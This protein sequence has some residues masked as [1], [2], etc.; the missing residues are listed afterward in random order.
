MDISM[1]RERIT[2]SE[3]SVTQLNDYVKRIIDNDKLLSAVSV[4]GEISNLTVHRSGHLYFTLKDEG[5]QVKAVMFRSAASRL[6][7]EP[8][9][10]MKV[11]V[12]CSVSVYVQTGSYQLYVNSMQPDGIGALYLAYEQL[13]NKLAEEG[14]FDGEHKL[15]IP[16][17]PLKIGVITS[18]TGAAIRDIIN[19]L[20]RR[21]PLA[22]VYLYPSLVQGEYAEENL[23]EAVDYF[24]KSKLADVVIIGRGGGSIEDLWAFNSERLARR[25]YECQVPVIS[26]V[27]HETD[28]TIC[29]FVSDMR[30]PTPSAA[31]ELASPDKFELLL[32][33]DA[34]LDRCSNILIS[35][36]Q[37]YEERLLSLAKSPYLT[38]SNAVFSS[39]TEKISELKKKL[40]DIKNIFAENQEVSLRYLSGKLESLNPLA[41]LKRGY[42]VICLSDRLVRLVDD[43]EVG[44]RVDITLSD[45]KAIA[46]IIEKRKHDGNK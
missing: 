39:Q 46:K 29:D 43:I 24:D 8:E 3:M 30:A 32:R 11:I 31:A 13:K 7:F 4:K 14:L 6:R 16:Q 20:G 19:V 36:I 27:G 9:N 26:A 15:P 1:L 45:G 35:K 2:S 33:L 18:P 21:F 5:G 17:I 41:V 38:D 28:F 23:I 42:S 44:D 10:G 25:I 37:R 12:R 34:F 22:K 40:A